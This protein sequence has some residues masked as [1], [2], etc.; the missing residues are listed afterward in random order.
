MLIEKKVGR[1][2]NRDE[3]TRFRT[4]CCPERGQ[5]YR[6]KAEAVDR[7]RREFSLDSAAVPRFPRLARLPSTRQ[8]RFT[9]GRSY[10]TADGAYL[11]YMGQGQA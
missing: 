5:F 1:P 9:I 7:A 3:L 10:A 6:E 11:R 4:R 8:L 2:R